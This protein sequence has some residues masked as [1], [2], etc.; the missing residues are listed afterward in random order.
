MASIKLNYA[1]SVAYQI[2]LIIVPVFTIPYISRIFGPQ[3]L[4]VYSYTSSISQYFVL[5][6]MLGLNNYGVRAI[7]IV[8]DDAESLSKTFS[9]IWL[10]QLGT[11]TM[12]LMLYMCFTL[13]CGG[14]YKVYFIIQILFV[15]S[16]IVDINWL[17]FGIEKFRLTVIR[18]SI[19]KILSLAAI[20]LFIRRA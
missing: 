18:N 5:F 7:A 8:R 17:F 3:N 6:A 11:S 20:F 19:I 4:G 12:A 15:A 1:Y 10:M 14:L 13:L 2:L 16:A 9:E